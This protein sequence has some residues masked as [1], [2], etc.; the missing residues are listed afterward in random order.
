MEIPPK[1]NVPMYASLSR[2]SPPHTRKS[3]LVSVF[4]KSESVKTVLRFHEI[5]KMDMLKA[6]LSTILPSKFQDIVMLAALYDH[7]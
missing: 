6:E 1:N 3:L 2:M 4:T 5:R 7:A